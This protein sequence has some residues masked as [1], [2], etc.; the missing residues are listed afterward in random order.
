M[1]FLDFWDNLID[2]NEG[3]SS[4]N[5]IGG[6]QKLVNDL[7]GSHTTSN[8]LGSTTSTGS[9]VP[10]PGV[11]NNPY[12]DIGNKSNAG[13]VNN[14][15]NITNRKAA[16]GSNNA[17]AGGG[18]KQTS[19][20]YNNKQV[21]PEVSAWTLSKSNL[22]NPWENLNKNGASQITWPGG[23]EKAAKE[24]NRDELEKISSQHLA[25]ERA[26]NEA[27]AEEEK[28]R[29]QR[30]NTSSAHLAEERAYNEAKVEEE[31]T[32]QINELAS[33]ISDM[34]PETEEEEIR[35][36]QYMQELLI[37]T[38]NNDY[39][40]INDLEERVSND[41]TEKDL[42]SGLAEFN[43]LIED[44]ES[45]SYIYDSLKQVVGGNYYEGD[46][47]LLGTAAQVALGLTGLDFAADIRDLTHDLT[48]WE[49]TPQH[50]GGTLL[51]GIGLLPVVGSLKFADELG[52]VAKN[53]IKSLDE[54]SDTVK[55]TDKALD[56]AE[57][58]AKAGKNALEEGAGKI[59]D[60]IIDGI[61]IVDGKVGGKI[62]IDEY[63]AIRK[64]S[65]KN[66][67]TKIMTLGKHTNGTDSYIVRAGNDSSYFDM[68]SE[69][70]MIKEKF[71][72]TNKE[73][74]DYFNRPALDDAISNS[75]T[76]RFSHNPLDYNGS[77][78]ADEWEHLKEVLN[79]TDERLIFEGGFWYVR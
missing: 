23:E 78:L 41:L 45:L 1:G 63:N 57:D 27:K 38:F 39:D 52:A 4:G 12:A 13:G 48:N 51:D 67:D 34:V 53:G 5:I 31:R 50:I 7:T 60:D 20:I 24:R 6:R 74:F 62:P 69:F 2:G 46:P 37:G 30:E 49:W 9:V 15:S 11:T 8:T 54:V 21:I 3:N 59:A 43:R 32:A 71:G 22:I 77:F 61:K 29:R 55:A 65:I 72:F 36:N 35:K 40:L 64:S 75:K 68:G 33:T 73:M 58:I 66:P 14:T 70:N 19:Y 18:E 76:I 42:N 28:N 79:L 26:Y 44:N 10:Q 25:E 56:G 47:T 17:K 16:T